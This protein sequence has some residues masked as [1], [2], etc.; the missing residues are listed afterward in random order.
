MRVTY[1]Y[2]QKEHALPHSK[3]ALKRHEQSERRRVRNRSVRSTART[4]L[5]RARTAIDRNASEREDLVRTAQST[6]DVSAR[7]GVIHPNNAARRKSRLMKRLNAA[8]AA[9]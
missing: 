5:A 1:P 6:L 8:Q 4:A 2:R 3:Q 9:G 7:K